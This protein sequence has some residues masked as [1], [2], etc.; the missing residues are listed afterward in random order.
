MSDH[1]S[2]TKSH[3]LPSYIHVPLFLYQDQRLDKA[4]LLIASFFHSLFSSGNSITAST[5]YLCFL[6][7]IKKRQYYNIMNDLEK[8]KYIK[9]TGFTNRKKIQWIYIPG[10]SIT[11]VEND[12]TAV[13]CTTVEELNTSAIE[14]SKLVHSSA[15]NYCN[16]VHTYNKEDNKDNTTTTEQ[17][18]KNSS[19]SNSSNPF[20]TYE[21]SKLT[22]AYANNPVE[23]ENIQTLDNFL[24]AALHSLV[25][26][27]QNISR[28]Q[29]LR[30]II[31]LVSQ[32]SFEEP[33]G[34]GK[35]SKSNVTLK[36]KT[37]TEDDFRKHE[38]NTEGF[39]WVSEYIQSMYQLD[40]LP[41]QEYY[42]MG[43]SGARG[44]KWVKAWMEVKGLNRKQK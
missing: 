23:T 31:K 36:I 26:R 16:A 42:Q 29:R 35:I 18:P 39:E 27:E 2:N 20:S 11:I 21:Q 4:A 43:L 7:N 37:P 6:A 17:P 15:L 12:T 13:Q 38:V 5:D 8:F 10:S 19:S 28:Q 40:R 24:S 41:T 25:N 33:K 32:G 22:E 3:K 14:C 44:Y 30:G 34:W 1:T 9:R